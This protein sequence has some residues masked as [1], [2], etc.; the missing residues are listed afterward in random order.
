MAF[1]PLYS[2][3]AASVT[4]DVPLAW[5]IPF[6]LTLLS[7]AL[8][9]L[10]NHH[11]WEKHYPKIT[12]LLAIPPAIYYLLIVRVP[13][14]WLVAME[15]YISFIILLA[16]L[17]IIS[18]GINIRVNRKATPLA[19]CTLLATGAFIAN[20][21]GTTG[22]SMLLIRP[23]L[24]MNRGHI[25]PYHIVFFI[26]IVANCGGLLTPIGDPPLFLGYLQGI[27]FLW[28]IDNLWPIWATL[29]AAL[30]AIFFIID[31]LDHRKA[32]RPHEP[33]PG[34]Q[35]HILGI[36]NF[37]FIS[38]VVFAVFRPGIFHAVGQLN[39]P[40]FSAHRIAD[41][42]FSRE[43]LMV[44][45]TLLSRRLTARE[46]YQ[47]N[48]FTFAPIK[49]VAIL[50]I[51]IFST[52]APALSWLHTNA[53]TLSIHTPGQYYFT[54]GSLSAILDNAPTY[55]TF[56]Q[57]RTS[58]MPLDA[59]LADSAA[60]LVVVAISAGAVLFGACTYIGNGPNFMVKSIADASGIKMPTFLAYLLLYALP[61]LIPL[62]VLI[63]LIFLRGV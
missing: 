3:I 27:P 43:L 22:A 51:A 17:Y 7:I 63:W 24:R 15:D 4:L 37:I 29:N 40:P 44:A 39:A 6:A 8:M 48:E 23:Y 53:H 14:P 2:I 46:I 56:L 47:H 35:V 45:A 58:N 52:M 50:F 54:A 28:T 33:L 12:L 49:E 38:M 20:I 57:I 26:F 55:M 16:S 21:F 19:N 18:G 42:L 59:I 41:L 30:L 11:W 62:Y 5:S 25:R 32:H 31:T 34:P 10:I 36:Q 60:N 61:I 1:G 9:P 13:G